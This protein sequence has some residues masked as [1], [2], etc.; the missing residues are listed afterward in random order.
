VSSEISS[1]TPQRSRG[2]PTPFRSRWSVKMRRR[3]SACDTGI[4][5]EK[6]QLDRVF[7]M[8]MQR[9]SAVDRR[10]GLG[11]GPTLGRNGIERHGGQIAVK[12]EGL[13]GDRVYDPA[14]SPDHRLGARRGSA[15]GR[16]GG[17]R[18]ASAEACRHDVVT[19]LISDLPKKRA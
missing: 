10:S 1:T 18:R 17:F 19:D 4:G 2:V 7:D 5:I 11:I 6:R 16:T 3:S 8:F 12:N 13:P 9:D 14:A 15:K